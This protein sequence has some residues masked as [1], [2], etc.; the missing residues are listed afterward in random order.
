MI[1]AIRDM[2][3]LPRFN[4]EK[5]K[6]KIQPCPRNQVRTHYTNALKPLSIIS[7]DPITSDLGAETEYAD[8]GLYE[9]IYNSYELSNLKNTKRV[10]KSQYSKSSPV[11]NHKDGLEINNNIRV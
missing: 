11:L 10:T 3:D 6:L 7:S 1:V 4:F 9:N 2:K 8:N 5:I